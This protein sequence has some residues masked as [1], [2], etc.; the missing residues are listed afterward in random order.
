MVAVRVGRSVGVCGERSMSQGMPI[1]C[2]PNGC[3]YV[4]GVYLSHSHPATSC[5]CTECHQAW[6]RDNAVA[7]AVAVW[8]SLWSS[9]ECVSSFGARI[10]CLLVHP[11]ISQ[12][13]P[14]HT[15]CSA[16]SGPASTLW[17]GQFGGRSPLW[18]GTVVSYWSWIVDCL[19]CSVV[20]CILIVQMEFMW[21][22]VCVIDIKIVWWGW[23][24]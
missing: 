14:H 3:I 4:Y 22:H 19:P 17:P 20:R 9:I 24:F 2:P 10:T 16:A 15:D 1:T 6:S 18:L 11:G 7:S 13:P 8:R 23:T 12:V 5:Q 21:L